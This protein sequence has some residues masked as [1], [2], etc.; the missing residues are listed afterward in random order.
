MTQRERRRAARR[1]LRDAERALRYLERL[2]FHHPMTVS[3]PA[4][5]VC[6]TTEA[7]HTARLAVARAQDGIRP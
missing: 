6:N 2:Q 5:P 7:I 3:I 4:C 1:A